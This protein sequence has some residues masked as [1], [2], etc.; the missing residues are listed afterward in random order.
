M[1][2]SSGPLGGVTVVEFAGIGPAPFAAMI[3]AGLGA[4]VI[5]IDRPA[6][7]GS[8]AITDLFTSDLMNRDRRS[9]ALDLKSPAAVEVTKRLVANADGIIEGFRPGVMERLGLG[10]DVLSEVNPKLTFVRM[11]G[12]G[13]TGPLAA[14][15]G[16]DLNF[17]AVTGLLNAIGT[18]ESPVIPLNLVGDFGGGG[19]MA[20]IGMLAGI[21]SARSTGKG[22]II[23]AAIVDGVSL[24]GTMLHG[25]IAS[26][27][28][29][30]QRHDN[31]LDGGAP[32]YAIYR[33]AD[34]KD[35]AL[36]ALEPKFF[37]ELCA[38][39][40]VA[41]DQAFGNQYGRD[42]WPEM[43]RVLTEIFAQRKREYFERLFEGADACVMAVNNFAEAEMNP[44][45][46]ERNVFEE[47]N[48]VTH[49]LL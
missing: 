20:A 24:M 9:I 18:K 47:V 36:A 15:A 19:T 7:N 17:I 34:G 35:I 2:D 16:H 22:S 3:L 32:F 27:L 33:C 43:R 25:L 14:R 44:H 28:W 45:L 29:S 11:T 41:G 21:L 37:A 26:G 12:W 10:P 49:P 4:E 42:T 1:K 30:P 13:Q 39:L 8:H 23:D 31:L 46:I 40:G 38:R 5:R 48:G 6:S